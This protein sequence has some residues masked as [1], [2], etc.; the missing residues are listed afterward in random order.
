LCTFTFFG[1]PAVQHV[2]LEPG[3]LA[4]VT[5]EFGEVWHHYALHHDIRSITELQG[6]VDN[7]ALEHFMPRMTSV[8]LASLPRRVEVH[9]HHDHFHTGVRET[10]KKQ[11]EL[12]GLSNTSE[13]S[14]NHEGAGIDDLRFRL[15]LEFDGQMSLP[16]SSWPG[17]EFLIS[18]Y[19]RTGFSL[20]HVN[21]QVSITLQGLEQWV[22]FQPATYTPTGNRHVRALTKEE[23]KAFRNQIKELLEVERSGS[24]RPGPWK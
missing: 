11:M 15:V 8:Q 20:L 17:L 18:S 21:E 13:T 7:Q 1:R 16:I 23:L 3:Q 6:R 14:S 5:G 10:S 22:D 2:A 12:L 9:V 4:G 24:L 19:F